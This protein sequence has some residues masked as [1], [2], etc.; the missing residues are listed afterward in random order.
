MPTYDVNIAELIGDGNGVVVEQADRCHKARIQVVGE[1]DQ[2][3][4]NRFV[5]YEVDWFLDVRDVHALAL[6]LQTHNHVRQV[7]Q[8]ETAHIR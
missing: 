6:R 7:L 5:S 1:D 2:L 4:L 3:I 8:M